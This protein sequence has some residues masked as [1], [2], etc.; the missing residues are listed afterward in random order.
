MDKTEEILALATDLKRYREAYY[1]LDPVATDQEYDTKKARLMELDPNHFEVVTVGAAPSKISVW[2]KTRHEIP[3]GSLN[4]ANSQEEFDK[5][6]SETGETNFFVTHK[7]DGSS[8]E[9]VYQAGKLVRCI[10]R[11]DGIIGEDVTTNISQVPSVPKQL[12][13]PVDVIIRGEI[14]MYKNVFQTLYANTYANPRNTAAGKVRDKKGG[15]A[16]CLNLAFLAY[17]MTSEDTKYLPHESYYAQMMTTLVKQGFLV[18]EYEVS[19]QMGTP[20]GFGYVHAEYEEIK[21]LRDSIPYEIDGVVIS[22]NDLVKLEELGEHNMR[23]KGQIAWK[24][25]PA[26]S[27]TRVLDVKW[28][29]GSSGRITPVA[30][31]EPVNIGGVTVTSI[32]LHNLSLFHDLK[33]TPGCRVLV[34]RRNDVIPYIEKNLNT[35]AE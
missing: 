22:V 11:G 13:D 18:P 4:K 21:K 3:M 9:L 14:V 1:N 12:K 23:P 28:Q 15:G 27:E 29:V 34:S 2:E 32:S 33:L 10:T 35:E 25:D 24:F 7:I 30:S 17:W 20:T 26:M 6:A 19:M 8:M 31:V 5:W 16:D